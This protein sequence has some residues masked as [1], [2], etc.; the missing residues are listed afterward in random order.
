MTV[1]ADAF[2]L[3]GVYAT[4]GTSACSMGLPAYA[5]WLQ[6]QSRTDE[7]AKETRPDARS[8]LHGRLSDV[9]TRVRI[10]VDRV[11]SFPKLMFFRYHE[12]PHAYEYDISEILKE[13][14]RESIRPEEKPV[15]ISE[16]ERQLSH[17]LQRLRDLHKRLDTA[18][19][20]LSD[21]AAVQVPT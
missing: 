11:L 18:C 17:Q 8:V 4:I 21:P 2:A 3:Y 9:M 5:M 10:H 1:G 15:V 14:R 13:R 16:E 6:K 19:R 20:P 12:A 7:K